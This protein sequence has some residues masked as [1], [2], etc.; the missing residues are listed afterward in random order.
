MEEEYP[1]DAAEFYDG[2]E[3]HPGHSYPEIAAP[4]W[5]RERREAADV[6]PEPEPEP[7]LLTPEEFRRKYGL[8]G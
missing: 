1:L 4:R 7:R 8:G 5:L 3:D 2:L 6:D